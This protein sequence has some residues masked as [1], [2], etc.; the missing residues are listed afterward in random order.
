MSQKQTDPVDTALQL[1]IIGTPEIVGRPYGAPGARTADRHERE[2][3][4]DR[5]N[6]IPNVYVRN[7]VFVRNKDY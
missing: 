1:H 5:D 3:F 2:S 7:P 6:I 4:L